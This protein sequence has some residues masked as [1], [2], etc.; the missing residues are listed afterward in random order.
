MGWLKR[1]PTALI[2]TLAVMIG[3]T[4]IAYLGGFVYLTANGIDTTDYRG[5]LNTAF[6]YV[7]ILLGAT[8]TVASVTAARSA[9]KAEDQ[10]NGLHQQQLDTV[11]N[12]AAIRALEKVNH[13]NVAD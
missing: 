9:A 12:S 10:T 7:G 13:D 6:N 1:A 3:C 4:T 8:T 11:A 5:L 2:V